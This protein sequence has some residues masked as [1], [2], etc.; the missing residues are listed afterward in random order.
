VHLWGHT[1]S[2]SFWNSK[3]GNGLNISVT[4]PGK[5]VAMKYTRTNDDKLAYTVTVSDK[6]MVAKSDSGTNGECL[7]GPDRRMGRTSFAAG[8]SDQT[9]T[10]SY[11]D[12]NEKYAGAV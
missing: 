8:K 10:L 2:S 5:Q 11:F 9:I 1:R 7:S 4:A 3:T 6:E 12:F